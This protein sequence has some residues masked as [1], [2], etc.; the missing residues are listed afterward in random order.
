[1]NSS[2]IQILHPY[3]EGRLNSLKQGHYPKHHLWAIDAFGNNKLVN[4]TSIFR[5]R[6]RGIIKLEQFF[7]HFFFVDYL[8]YESNFFLHLKQK[9]LI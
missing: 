2:R 7:D 1:M 8:V 4:Q 9:K 3:I 6:N 5:K